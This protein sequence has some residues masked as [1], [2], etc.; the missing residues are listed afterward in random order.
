MV[1]LIR[2]KKI[3]EHFSNN[4]F[5]YLYIFTCVSLCCVG[6][7]SRLWPQSNKFTK[8]SVLSCNFICYY[9]LLPFFLVHVHSIIYTFILVCVVLAIVLPFYL[10]YILNLQKF[11][12]FVL[13]QLLNLQHQR[14]QEIQ[15]YLIT[16]Q[17]RLN[18]MTKKMVFFHFWQQVPTMMIKTTCQKF[19]L[20]THMKYIKISF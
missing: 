18:Y 8:I 15:L 13:Q 6:L 20:S 3:H 4:I 12:C 9:F 17:L 11:I 14:G 5:Y 2:L 10:L 19:L 16:Y 1:F 7:I